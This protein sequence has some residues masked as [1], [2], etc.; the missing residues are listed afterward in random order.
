[1]RSDIAIVDYGMGNLRSVQKAIEA[2]GARADIVSDPSR[3][4]APGMLL[5]GVGAFRDAMD[6]LHRQR[7]VEPILRHIGEGKPFLGVCLGLHLLFSEGEEFGRHQGLGVIPGRVVRFAPGKKIPHMGWNTVTVRKPE[8]VL[9]GVADG[10]SFYFVHS[11]HGVPEDPEWIG[12]VTDYQETFV[13]AVC[14]GN[15]WATQF[16]PEKSQAAGL[17]LYRTFVEIVSGGGA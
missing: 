2:V 6:N 16:H 14:R 3:L 8:G 5:P 12:A 11:F 10:T 15:V 1:M 7:M 17:A 4:D 13:S 9:R